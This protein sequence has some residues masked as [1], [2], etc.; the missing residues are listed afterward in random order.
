MRVTLTNG[1]LVESWGKHAWLILFLIWAVHLVLSARDFFPFLQ[2]VCVPCLP[3]GQSPI[4]ASAGLT[5]SQLATSD[6]K[7]ATYLA[8]VLFDDGISGV[9]LAIFGMVV[10]YTS[11]RKGQK[12]AWY[13]SWLNPIGII[14][15]QL[16]IY[17]LTA[18]ILTIILTF[19]FLILCMLGLF[20]PY[21]QFFPRNVTNLPGAEKSS[22][23]GQSRLGI[24]GG[25]RLHRSQS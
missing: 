18:S 15:A 19:T 1:K 2:D 21:R 12:W 13:L 10:S 23:E 14:A 3:G 11:Y 4:L 7:F 5:W 20:L 16:N 9:G 17:F 24:G 6:P 22:L 25:S 8:S